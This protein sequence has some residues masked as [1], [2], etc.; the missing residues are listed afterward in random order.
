MTHEEKIKMFRVVFNHK[1]LL[2]KSEQGW[3]NVFLNSINNYIWNHKGK[4]TPVLSTKQVG[5]IN[6]YYTIIQSNKDTDVISSQVI[7]IPYKDNYVNEINNQI[8]TLVTRQRKVNQWKKIK[9]YKR[10]NNITT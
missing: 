1:H 4:D 9:Q 10:D 3:A 5:I 6:K 2:P 7:N 8:N